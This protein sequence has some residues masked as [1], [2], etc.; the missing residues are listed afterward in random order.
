MFRFVLALA[1]P[2]A[3][4]S[5][6]AVA[7]DEDAKEVKAAKELVKKQA[8]NVTRF[9]HPPGK[10]K[11]VAFND[12]AKLKDGFELVYTFTFD[13]PVRKNHSTK[14][15][16]TYDKA[17]KL[18]F[19]TKMSTTAVEPF[20]KDVTAKKLVELKDLVKSVAAVKDDRKLL[21]EVEDAKDSKP[22][23]EIWLRNS[24]P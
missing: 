18:D 3:F 12:F 17:G 8:E 1:V 16:F 14:L 15:K 10:H 2:L 7:Q 19:I 9:A 21:K 22:L 4:L 6:P 23:L 24:T 20:T 5:A 11:D 13:G